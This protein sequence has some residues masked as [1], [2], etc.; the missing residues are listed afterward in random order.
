MAQYKYEVTINFSGF[1]SG[2]TFKVI[3]PLI[4]NC[5]TK[6]EL[7]KELKELNIEND[8]SVTRVLIELPQLKTE[9]Y[10]STS[11]NSGLPLYS[12]KRVEEDL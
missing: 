8:I 4:F 12:L 2:N 9:Y 7:L 5:K 3:E 1:G 6:R 10:Y 11:K